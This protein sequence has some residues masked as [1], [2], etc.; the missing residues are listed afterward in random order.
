M[1]NSD[2][3]NNFFYLLHERIEYSF[4]LGLVARS[5]AHLPGNKSV[6]G[7]I[8]SFIEIGH[9][10]I[11]FTTLS[12]IQAGQLSVTGARICNKYWLTT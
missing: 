6:M 1:P 8:L 9:E 2:P 4:Q 3:L 7:S 11:S 10:I 12:L 5:D